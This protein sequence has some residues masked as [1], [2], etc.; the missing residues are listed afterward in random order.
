MTK[1]VVALALVFAA[2]ALM[3]L[4]DEGDRESVV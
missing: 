2:A 1:A 4:V 3:L